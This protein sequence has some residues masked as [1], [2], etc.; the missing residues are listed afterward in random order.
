MFYHN[1]MVY[2]GGLLSPCSLPSH[3]LDSNPSTAHTNQSKLANLQTTL[4]IPSTF[5]NCLT[6][7]M[8]FTLPTTLLVLL[9]VATFITAAPSNLNS[10]Q[11]L[12]PCGYKP[13]EPLVLLCNVGG[14]PIL[15]HSCTC[16]TIATITNV[17][18]G[19]ANCTCV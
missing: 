1:T 9:N 14:K 12:S 10:R 18:T 17:N 13:Y 3:S 16:A 11:Q 4:T 8:Q 19:I 6:R 15:Y 5:F 2:K 7:T